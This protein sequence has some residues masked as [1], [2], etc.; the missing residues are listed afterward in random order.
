MA[1]DT[2]ANTRS[3][4]DGRRRTS[5]MNTRPGARWMIAPLVVWVSGCSSPLAPSAIV[6]YWSGRDVPARFAAVQIRLEQQGSGVRGTACRLDG[7]A[8]TFSGVPVTVDNSTVTFTANPGTSDEHAFVGRFS[9]DG[10]T[11]TGA[12]T[13]S[14][15]TEIVL[16]HGGN[17]CADAR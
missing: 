15:S 7:A 12:W 14:P 13:V 17:L 10:K 2:Q 8:L 4:G 16:Q 9:S 1:G 5:A 6:G 11:L 3:G